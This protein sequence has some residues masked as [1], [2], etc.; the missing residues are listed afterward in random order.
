MKYSD[1]KSPIA[2]GDAIKYA[3][4]DFSVSGIVEE[5]WNDREIKLKG[6]WFFEP[7][8]KGRIA[9]TDRDAV[10]AEADPNAH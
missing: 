8:E 5:I 3:D 6:G 10:A 9:K 2:V 1:D 7:S 4:G